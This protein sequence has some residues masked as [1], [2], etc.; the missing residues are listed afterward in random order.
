[1]GEYRSQQ[2]CLNGHQITSRYEDLPERRAEFC[3]SC[4]ASTVH[5][6]P[7]CSAS[8]R[9]YYARRNVVSGRT[10]PVPKFCHACGET[11]PWTANA[12]EAAK[13]LANELEGLSDEDREILKG[14]LSDITTD[15]PRTELGATRIKRIYAKAG[16]A[17]KRILEG[18]IVNIATGKALGLLGLG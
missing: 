14:A 2:V 11:Y 16:D 18:V 1:M 9:G 15:G 10:V 7:N 6:C 3:S 13:E 5:E 17:G 12:L 4:G 8:I